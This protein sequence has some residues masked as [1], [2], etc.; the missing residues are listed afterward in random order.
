MPLPSRVPDADPDAALLALLGSLRDRDYR[1]VTPTPASHARVIARPG[2][3]VA[4]GLADIFGW[5]LP[6]DAGVLEPDLLN[7]LVV[8]DM[9]ESAGPR[10][11]ARCRVSTVHGHSFLHSAYPT[12]DRDAVFFGPDSYRFADFIRGRPRG[13]DGARIVDIGT[14]AGVGAIVAAAACPQARVTMTD[15]NPKALRFARI[16]AAFAGVEAEFVEGDGLDA[17]RGGIDVALANPPYIIDPS[18]RAYRDGGDMHGGQLSLDLACEAAARLNPGGRLLLYTG[19]A[20]VDG[21]DPL[22]EAL[23]RSMAASGCTLDYDELDPDVFGEELE[24]PHYADVDRI[25]VIGAVATK[26]D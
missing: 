2:R 19:S 21:R 16:N 17:V 13:C 12:E 5:S 10:L 20:I 8:A 3:R 24:Q 22:R 7:L 1:F 6:F 26:R 11:R 9:V 4:R 14:G 25:A 15:I 18:G 23:E